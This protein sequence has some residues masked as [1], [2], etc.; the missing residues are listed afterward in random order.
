MTKNKKI[1]GLVLGSAM[2]VGGGAV[3]D[4]EINPYDH[5]GAKYEMKINNGLIEISD[6][7]PKLKFSKWGDE[8]FFIVKHSIKKKN[9]LY[10]SLFSKK[11]K[12]K[13]REKEIHFYP[14]NNG[15]FEF[16]IILL[17][18][19]NTNIVEFEIET[20][21]LVFYHQPPLDEEM[22]NEKC[23]TAACTATDCCGSHR[24]IN[25]VGSYAVYHESKT[26][27]YSK[28]GGKNYMAGKAFHMPYPYLIDSNGWEV[29]AENFKIDVENKLL[30]VTAPQDFIDNAA[31]PVRHAAGLTFGY[32]TIGGSTTVN[33]GNYAGSLFTGAVG[34]GNSI[35]GY[36][37]ADNSNAQWKCGLY[38]KS[39][40]SLVAS[41]TAVTLGSTSHA[42]YT[43]NFSSSP[44]LSAVDYVVGF[45]A[46]DYYGIDYVYYD[47]GA[48]NQG[49]SGLGSWSTL[50]DPET[51]NTDT[52]KY[53]IYCTY[54][55]EEEEERRVIKIE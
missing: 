40:S 24:P 41:S 14:Q 33:Y 36:F 39:D 48:A 27:D 15:E 10:R 32:T 25:M 47:T 17:K 4:D 53:S 46:D 9:K 34:T 20:K 38:L 3:I 22:K 16:E 7:D 50:I 6:I 21:G 52:T 5:C 51:F 44:N 43:A 12:W 49:H 54:T 35:T 18:K 31:Y 8:A 13:G 11:I 23:W 19:P 42:W 37:G 55:A 26:G 28:I 29:R 2:V 30:A 45:M 1:A